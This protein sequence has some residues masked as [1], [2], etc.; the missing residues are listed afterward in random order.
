MYSIFAVNSLEPLLHSRKTKLANQTRARYQV[1]CSW[2]RCCFGPQGRYLQR[3][4]RFTVA[5]A[6]IR[7]LLF[8]TKY[9]LWQKI[10][11]GI[12]ICYPFC[13]KI[14]VSWGNGVFLQCTFIFPV[15]RLIIWSR[16]NWAMHFQLPPARVYRHKNLWLCSC[17]ASKPGWFLLTLLWMK[18]IEKLEQVVMR[19]LDTFWISFCPQL[20]MSDVFGN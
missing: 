8:Q 1:S 10:L 17:A 3:I 15:K 13:P 20:K 18:S 19:C 16:D 6:D 11:W 7:T 2:Y 12:W 14:T 9:N 4:C 5:S